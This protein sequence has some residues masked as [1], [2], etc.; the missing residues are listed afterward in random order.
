MNFRARQRRSRRSA[1]G[2]S[3]TLSFSSMSRKSARILLRDA[4]KAKA[5]EAGT[6]REGSKTLV[7]E[8]S[9]TVGLL[10]RDEQQAYGHLRVDLS[11][12]QSRCDLLDCNTTSR[13]S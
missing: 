6:V 5:S 11:L 4:V 1:F 2:C 3:W 13:P 7:S 8:P 12:R 9:L 10:A